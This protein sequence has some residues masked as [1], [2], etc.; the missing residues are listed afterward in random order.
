MNNATLIHITRFFAFLIFQVLILKRL[1]V[2]WEGPVFINIILYPLFIILLPLRT[3]RVLILI[4][5]FAMGILVDMGYDSLGVHAGASVLTA[6]IRPWILAW[7]APRDGYNV[8]YSPNLERLGS[9][10]FFRYA[11]IMMALHLLFYYSLDAFSPVFIGDILL[12]TLLSFPLSMIFV[13]IV[14]LIFKPKE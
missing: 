7:L 3:P 8:N 12:K 4:A 1:S 6:Y 10:W 5:A 2:G 13:I 14:T 11:S 9:R